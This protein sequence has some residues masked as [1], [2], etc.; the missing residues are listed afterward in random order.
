M[1]LGMSYDEFW[2]CDPRAYKAYREKYKIS[3]QHENEVLWLQGM[4]IYEAMCN[5]APRFNSLKPKKGADYPKKPYDIFP[6][7]QA[8]PMSVEDKG[9]AKM[10]AWMERTNKK[11]GR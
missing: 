4:Y 1:A 7:Q 2:N 8:Q 9:M 3:Y 10:M 5:V 6:E 11:H